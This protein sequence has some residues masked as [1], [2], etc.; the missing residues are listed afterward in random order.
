MSQR[1][2]SLLVAVVMSVA[3]G[4]LLIALAAPAL[5]ADVTKQRLENADT[6]PQNWLT[7]FQNYSSHRFSRLNQINRDNVKNLKVAFTF[8]ITSSLRGT[9]KTN[10]Q[11]APLVDDG[12]LYLDDGMGMIY[13]LDVRAGDSAK[14]MWK[15]DAAVSIEEDKRTRG[16]AFWGNNVYKD[17]TDGRVI[18]VNRD[19]GEIIW[20]KPVARRA[21]PK[22]AEFFQG[23]SFTAAPLAAD[24]KIIVGQSFGDKATRGWVAGLDAANG[25]EVWRTY[26]VPGPG[27]KGHETW[28]DDHNAWKTG[29]GSLWTTGSYDP[30]QKVS[31]WG[32]ANPVPM[33]DPEFRPGDNLF[34]DSVLAFDNDTGAIK[35]YFQLVPNESWDYDEISVNLLYDVD[36]AGQSRKVLG[37]FARNG[38][39]YILDRTNG[40]FIGARQYVDKVTWTAGLDP[41]TGKP[42][43]YDAALKVQKYIPATRFARGDVNAKEVCPTLLGGVRW[44]PPAYNPTKKVAYSGSVDGCFTHKITLGSVSKAPEGGIKTDV[45]GGNN[46]AQPNQW[47]P[48]NRTGMLA[49]VDATTGKL[50][51]KIKPKYDNQSGVVATAGGVLFTAY[52]DGRITAHNDD[53]LEELW[54]FNTGIHVKGAPIVYSAGGKEFVA[55]IAGGQLVASGEKE[56]FPELKHLDTGAMLYVFSL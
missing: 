52:I 4:G 36:I 6:E 42:L 54:H 47:A 12:M 33:F 28:A 53:T 14:V 9:N 39:Y 29:G 50:I 44:Q 23:E 25:N 34:T 13:K 2:P 20:D 10:L 32:T 35:W 24:G 45:G 5:A 46:G 19:T 8:P 7:V 30:A 37:K 26:T 11:N 38:F 27:E 3:S 55:I 51:A 43:E 40:Q 16:I 17:L 21:H 49:S 56:G 22:G 15:A 48:V 41:K 18:A 31:I 1:G